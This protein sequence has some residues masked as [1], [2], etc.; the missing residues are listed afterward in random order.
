LASYRIIQ[1][2]LTN[3][4]RHA[5]ATSVDVDLQLCT[6]APEIAAGADPAIR[7]RIED[8]GVGMPRDLR[9]GFGL[10]GVS[11]RVRKFGGNLKIINGSRAGTLIEA[12]IPLA[13][14]SKLEIAES[15]TPR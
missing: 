9:F 5:N 8:D 11:E 4:A 10:L 1:E 13:C 12:T 15:W 14:H 3:V 6:T 7:I 2:C